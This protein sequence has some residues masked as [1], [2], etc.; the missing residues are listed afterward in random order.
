MKKLLFIGLLLSNLLIFFPLSTF[1][2]KPI[3]NAKQGLHSEYTPSEGSVEEL[4]KDII[5]TLSL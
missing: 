3:I 4:Y 1:A 5:V 2:I